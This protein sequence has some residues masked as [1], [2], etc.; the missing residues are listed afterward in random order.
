MIKEIYIRNYKSHKSTDLLLKPISIFIGPNNSGKSGILQILQLLKQSIK[1]GNPHLLIPQK[2]LAR[3]VQR[4]S[5]QSVQYS[6]PNLS[7]DV[8]NYPDVVSKNEN[9]INIIWVSDVI[10]K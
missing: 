10:P 1:S 2:P 7:V 5:N 9:K 3:T 4:G 6:Y 8:G